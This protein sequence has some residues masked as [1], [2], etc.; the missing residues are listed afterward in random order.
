MTDKE[1]DEILEFF[2]NPRIDLIKKV[3]YFERLYYRSGIK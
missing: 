2:I 1:K 3:I